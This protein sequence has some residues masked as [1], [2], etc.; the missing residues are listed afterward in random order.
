M[1]ARSAKTRSDAC[2]HTTATTTLE[3]NGDG[4]SIFVLYTV[5]VQQHYADDTP[6]SITGS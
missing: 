1:L 6:S 5:S 3:E 4:Q 2:I